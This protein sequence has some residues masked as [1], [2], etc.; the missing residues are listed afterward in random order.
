MND[1]SL[2]CTQLKSTHLFVGNSV[3]ISKNIL[4]R[5]QAT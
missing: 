5:H 3:Q 1:V 4:Q 2:R